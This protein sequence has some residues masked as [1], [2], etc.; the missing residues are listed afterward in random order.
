MYDIFK[1]QL[2]DV[3][4]GE[5]LTIG[6]G[7]KLFVVRIHALSGPTQTTIPAA[8]PD[9]GYYKRTYVTNSTGCLR[10]VVFLIDDRSKMNLTSIVSVMNR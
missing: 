8:L 2:S 5:S 3:V 6:G 10:Q 4:L 9:H 1:Q 7:G